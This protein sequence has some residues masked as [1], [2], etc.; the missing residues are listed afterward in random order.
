MCQCPWVGETGRAYGLWDAARFGRAGAKV[1]WLPRN[2][3]Q[4]AWIREGVAGD[5]EQATM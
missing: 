5:Q 1:S 3:G 4:T 2:G